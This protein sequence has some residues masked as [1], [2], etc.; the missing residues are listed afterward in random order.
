MNAKHIK[1]IKIMS[2]KL[3]RE[4]AKA[5]KILYDAATHR[6]KAITVAGGDNEIRLILFGDI[7]KIGQD[8]VM[9][10]SDTAIKNLSEVGRPMERMVKDKLYLINTSVITEDGVQLGK[11]ADFSFIPATGIVEEIEITKGPIED[12]KTGRNKIQGKNI[13]KIGQNT[14]IVSHYIDEQL[15]G[16]PK[17]GLHGMLGGM[18][19]KVADA[20]KKVSPKSHK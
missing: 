17:R 3:S 6:I 9:V 12:L 4:I 13:V 14:T 10:E 18:Q 2:L 11:I 1:G 16:Q 19:K 8:A 7:K 5:D 20:Q 15:A